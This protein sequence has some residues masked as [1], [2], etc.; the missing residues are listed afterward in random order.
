MEVTHGVLELSHVDDC[1]HLNHAQNGLTW[2]A[3]KV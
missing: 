1:V 2:I 3:L